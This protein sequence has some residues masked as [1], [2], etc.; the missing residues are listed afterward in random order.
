MG[1]CR[2]LQQVLHRFSSAPRCRRQRLRALLPFEVQ[3]RIALEAFWHAFGLSVR[4][5][6]RA[7]IAKRTFLSISQFFTFTVL[8]AESR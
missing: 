7:I 1:S 8:N 4:A 3:R 6:H 2:K 5:S